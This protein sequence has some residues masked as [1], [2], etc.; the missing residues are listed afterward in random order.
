MSVPHMA[1]CVPKIIKFGP[2]C[3]LCTVSGNKEPTV[4]AVFV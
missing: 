4:F 3:I 1:I 2:P